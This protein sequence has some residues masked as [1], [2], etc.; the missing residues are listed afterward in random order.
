[1]DARVTSVPLLAQPILASILEG[2]LIT[3]PAFMRRFAEYRLA[4]IMYGAM[5]EVPDTMEMLKWCMMEETQV[6]QLYAK[7]AARAVTAE[8]EAYSKTQTP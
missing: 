6:Q 7:V 1:L 8:M 4:T 3:D 5:R 2:P